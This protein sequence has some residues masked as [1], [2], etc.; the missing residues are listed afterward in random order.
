MSERSSLAYAQSLDQ[1][2]ELWTSAREFAADTPLSK[3]FEDAIERFTLLRNAVATWKVVGP[4]Q[5]HQQSFLTLIDDSI[6]WVKAMRDGGDVEAAEADVD[7][8]LRSVITEVSRLLDDVRRR[9]AA[10][11]EA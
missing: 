2:L 6:L 9:K 5:R 4:Q 8:S 1:T 7:E 11:P 10:D 3:K